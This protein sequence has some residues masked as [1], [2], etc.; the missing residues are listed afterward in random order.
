[1]VADARALPFRSGFAGTIVCNLPFGRRYHVEPPHLP[2]ALSGDYPAKPGEGVTLW[3]RQAFTEFERG[4]A[5]GGG[6]GVLLPASAAFKA[7]VLRP[8]AE[9]L[10]ARHPIK[11]LGL[12]TTIWAFR[13]G[14]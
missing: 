3:L 8:R 4:V 13:A 10:R 6:I 7:A 12:P 2:P 14:G 5:R 11:L 9:R 1:A